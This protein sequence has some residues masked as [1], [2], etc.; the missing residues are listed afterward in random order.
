MVLPRVCDKI[1]Q[2]AAQTFLSVRFEAMFK[3]YTDKNVCATE[4]SF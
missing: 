1:Y 2:S 3:S 4:A